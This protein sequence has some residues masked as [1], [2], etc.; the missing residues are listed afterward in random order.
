MK[1]T[2]IEDTDKINFM[3]LLLLADEEVKMIE[4]WSPNV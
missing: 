4:K 3:D 2:N 1:I